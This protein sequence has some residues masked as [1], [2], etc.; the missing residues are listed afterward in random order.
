MMISRTAL[1]ATVLSGLG[2]VTALAAEAPAPEHWIAAGASNVS[3]VNTQ[4]VIRKDDYAV[5]WRMQNFPQAEVAEQGQARSAK[6]QVEYNCA[7]ARQRAV[8]AEMYSGRMGTGK[9]V[10]LSYQEHPWEPAR[11]DGHAFSI[12]CGQLAQPAVIASAP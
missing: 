12:A 8:S 4:S 5:I 3:F 6:I 11:P 10:G 9:L 7:A 2:A 1:F